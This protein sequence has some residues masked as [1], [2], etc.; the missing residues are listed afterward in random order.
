MKND[1]RSRAGWKISNVYVLDQMF[2][3]VS[4]IFAK[5]IP[6]TVGPLSISLLLCVF[7]SVFCSLLFLTRWNKKKLKGIH[8]YIV[9]VIN[10]KYKRYKNII[11][12]QSFLSASN[13]FTNNKLYN[14][15]F[16]SWWPFVVFCGDR[17]SGSSKNSILFSVKVPWNVKV[18]SLF[19]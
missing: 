1:L 9:G 5:W 7:L 13:S 4:D 14:Y 10:V 17:L 6:R 3:T 12:H 19:P 15:T 8:K 2:E 16:S 18:K 11:I